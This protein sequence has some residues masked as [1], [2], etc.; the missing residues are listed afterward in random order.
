VMALYFGP[1]PVEDGIGRCREFL[2]EVSGEGAIEAA[3]W[4]GLAGLLAMRGDFEDARRLWASAGERF[5]ELGLGYRRA[6]RSTIGA[7]IETLAGDPDAAEQ[8]LRRGYE[9]LERMGEKGARAVVAA[10]LAD[11]LCRAGRDHEAAEYADIVAELAAGDDVV[12]QALCRCVRAKLFAR[13]GEADRAVEL[14]REAT[15]LVEGMD[16]PDL[17][18][19]TLLSL[20]EVLEAAGKRAESAKIVARAQALYEKKGNVAA[21][22]RMVSETNTEGRPQ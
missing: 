15:G 1:T 7:D 21:G 10:Y 6:V 5:D 12:P 11:T 19:L 16:F 14:A 2:A 18:A 22:R 9:T 13:H 20:A 4:S 17:Q 3:I 8:E